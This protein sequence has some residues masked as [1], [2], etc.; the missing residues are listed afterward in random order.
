MA[1]ITPVSQPHV[2]TCSVGKS[3]LSLRLM[4]V[5]GKANK[6][7]PWHEKQL[8]WAKTPRALLVTGVLT[9]VSLKIHY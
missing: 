5:V 8:G 6:R 4:D 3:M 9:T 7:G 1:E 2:L